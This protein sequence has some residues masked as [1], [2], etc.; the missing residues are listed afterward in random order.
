MNPISSYSPSLSASP[1]FQEAY[2]S[3]SELQVAR[4][5][6]S[7][8]QS[9]D[10]TI[11]T[12]EGDRVTISSNQQSQVQ[13]LTYEGLAKK[14]VS[15]EYQGHA[16]TKESLA[17]FE[18]EHFESEKN[19]SISIS[20]EGDLNEQE[21]KD[22]K[23]ALKKID[24]VMTEFLHG[25]DMVDAAVKSMEIGKLDTIAS[26]EANYRYEKSAI[27]EQTSLKEETTYS[28]GSNPETPPLAKIENPLNHV[29]SLIEELTNIIKE[30]EIE[31]SRFKKPIQKL[32][33]DYRNNPTESEPRD[34]HRIRMTEWIE[35]ELLKKLSSLSAKIKMVSQPS[36]EE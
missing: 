2:Q 32:F 30:S 19:R 28:R 8:S 9:K 10:I 36:P 18:G 20:V 31:L 33:S 13:Y 27:L 7:E 24:K 21:L 15:G 4:L 1:G 22:I 34:N 35:T 29:K 17:M 11:F 25:G 16:L 12:D 23:E 14:R 5:S 26:L 6:V 3:Y